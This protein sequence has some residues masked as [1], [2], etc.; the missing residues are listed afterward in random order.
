MKNTKLLHEY[1][2]HIGKTCKTTRITCEYIPPK[3]LTLAS[4]G[5]ATGFNESKLVYLN[6]VEGWNLY[7]SIF[8]KVHLIVSSPTF[9]KLTEVHVTTR[10][11]SEST[12]FASESR[13]FASESTRLTKWI[14]KINKVN[15]QN[16]Q[17]DQQSAWFTIKLTRSTRPT[18]KLT[19]STRPT[20]KSTRLTSES[21][22]STSESTKLQ[23]QQANQQDQQANQQD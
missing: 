2:N 7:F 11:T 18:I 12:R 22:R 9:V 15:Q 6:D 13:R 19:R 1:V 17:M 14:N 4:L 23:N 21:T 8:I 5:A 16:L 20:S 10:S 3:S